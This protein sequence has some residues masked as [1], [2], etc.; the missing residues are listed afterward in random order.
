MSDRAARAAARLSDAERADP[1]ARPV[2]RR[3]GG[4][5][6]RRAAPATAG[7]WSRRC[8]GGRTSRSPS[9]VL[10]APAALLLLREQSTISPG[11]AARRGRALAR[12]PRAAG[13]ADAE[14]PVRRGAVRLDAPRRAEPTAPPI[15]A[16]ELPWLDADA[17][18]S[19]R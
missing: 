1:A 19:A 5:C 6:S 2:A 18:A 7:C 13:R 15:D 4:R 14:R 16:D 17:E 9:I 10:G 8:R 11:P 3:L 12:P